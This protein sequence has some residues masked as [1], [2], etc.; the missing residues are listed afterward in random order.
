MV[1]R[2]ARQEGAGDSPQEAQH[3]LNALT[4]E[5]R[6]LQQ[7]VVAQLACDVARLQSE[8]SRLVR[9][10]EALRERP[11]S[12]PR[13]RARVPDPEETSL[14]A[15]DTPKG[16]R[17]RDRQEWVQHLAQSI[18]DRLSP[19]PAIDPSTNGSRYLEGDLADR[20]SALSQHLRRMENLQ[21]QGEAILTALMDR[22]GEQLHNGANGGSL[23]PETDAPPPL[24]ERQAFVS[25]SPASPAEARSPVA[26][27][28]PRSKTLRQG[29]VLAF[30]STA[31]LALFNVSIKLIFQE[32]A[33]F[34]QSRWENWSGI[35]EPTWGNAL[36]VLFLR[37]AI[38]ML[39][40]PAMAKWLYPPCWQDLR[41]LTAPRNRIVLGQAIG[42]GFL[43]FLSQVCVYKAIGEMPTA[44]AIGLFF[45]FGAIVGLGS[46]VFLGDRVSD[47][48]WEY[49]P[50]FPRLAI[51]A[52]VLV[53]GWL[54]LENGAD[55]T[56]A[57]ISAAIAFAAYVLLSQL[58]AK[59][60]HPIPFSFV[61]FSLAF[62]LSGI[63]VLLA[64]SFAPGAV[65]VPSGR[66]WMLLVWGVGLGGLSL[67]SYV[68]NIQSIRSGG[69]VP[70]SIVGATVPILTAFCGWSI[71]NEAVPNPQILGI[72]LVTIGAIGL[73]LERL[74]QA[75]QR[76]KRRSVKGNR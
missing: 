64:P 68:A 16:S 59:K 48:L 39:L 50:T 46:W 15:D 63:G 74:F 62:A 27:S 72:V 6:N 52:L 9:E 57:A 60:L 51:S 54:C 40:L 19:S 32:S 29:I 36:L 65:T 42:S 21:H 75:K 58:C 22:M 23:P 5:L 1:S 49:R 3:I 8:K 2:D 18:A 53:G 28:P 70:S 73:S 11:P 41:Q 61:N 47:S 7:D 20:R 13:D 69:A 43:L 35:L 4:Q 37:M 33:P 12:V 14:E 17:L 30:I 76:A 31:L 71:A 10:I 67:L 44:V 45:T 25:I 55:G 24:G 26:P 66:E 34:G 38:V 56:F